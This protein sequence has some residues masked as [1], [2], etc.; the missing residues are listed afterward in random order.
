MKEKGASEFRQKKEEEKEA[1]AL[2]KAK[3]RRIRSWEE[4]QCKSEEDFISTG[5]RRGYKDPE[6]WARH[7]WE[8]RLN[9]EKTKIQEAP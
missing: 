5:K 6:G 4:A 9:W 7:K 1:K 8:A 2:E 3:L